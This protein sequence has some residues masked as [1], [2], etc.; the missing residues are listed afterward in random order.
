MLKGLIRDVRTTVVAVVVASLVVAAPAVAVIINADKVDGKD[1]VG[2]AATRPARA[3]KLVATNRRGYL[4]N[5][6]L[7]KAKDSNLLDGLDSTG[8]LRSNGKAVDSDKLDGVDSTGFLRSNGKAVDSDKLDGLDSTAFGSPLAFAT[9]TSAGVLLD[10]RGVASTS[11]TGVGVYLVNFDASV[12]N[13]AHL[14]TA[15]E[16]AHITHTVRGARYGGPVTQIRVLLYNAAGTAVD[17]GFA[18]TAV[19]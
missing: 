3:G 7:V 5:N 14:A 19:C 6:I 11:R 18:V 17:G 8:F 16:G 13:C 1:A 9:V 12:T 4:P 2:A 10:D 15:L